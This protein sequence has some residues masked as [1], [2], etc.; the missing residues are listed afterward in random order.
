MTLS[1]SSDRR[2]AN[3]RAC[4]DL[5]V[6]PSRDFVSPVTRY[7]A[8][9]TTA[10][11]GILLPCTPRTSVGFV[12]WAVRPATGRLESA[13]W[14]SI[15]RGNEGLRRATGRALTRRLFRRRIVSA[16][17]LSPGKQ[18]R[19]TFTWRWASSRREME[20]ESQ[21]RA[22]RDGRLTGFSRSAI[23]VN[24]FSVSP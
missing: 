10:A 1:S 17:Q 18:V 14:E 21:G 13:A 20:D 9:A 22:F 2:R 15:G 24:T 4:A 7:S 19:R 5:E 11:S 12:M 23:W 16:R 3:W 8:S 6:A